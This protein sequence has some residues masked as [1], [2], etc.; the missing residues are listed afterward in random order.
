MHWSFVKSTPDEH[1]IK[2]F[3]GTGYFSVLYSDRTNALDIIWIQITEILFSY[4]TPHLPLK[5]RNRGAVRE[6]GKGG[7]P[8][9]SLK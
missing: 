5:T 6:P 3:V 8:E 1:Q 4:F 9:Q 2:G 7:N